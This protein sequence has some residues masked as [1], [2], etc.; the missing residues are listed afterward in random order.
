M[1]HKPGAA[2]QAPAGGEG[3]TCQEQGSSCDRK[4][5]GHG[6]GWGCSKE[7]EREGQRGRERD[8]GGRDRGAEREGQG[9]GTEGGMGEGQVERGGFGYL[10]KIT[11]LFLLLRV[12]ISANNGSKLCV[13]EH[14]TM[15]S[16]L[17]KR[18]LSS[19]AKV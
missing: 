5:G 2:G 14:G 7:G 3:G 4:R 11:F 18:P 12:I 17:P 19:S 10:R 1:S 15:G 13:E 16:N 8:R 9:G 6:G